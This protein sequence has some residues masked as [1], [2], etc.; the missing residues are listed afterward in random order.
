MLLVSRLSSEIVYPQT[1]RLS[2]TALEAII[3]LAVSEA[4]RFLLALPLIIYSYNGSNVHR[5]VYNKNK[6]LGWLGAVFAAL[7]LFNFISVSITN[8]KKEIGI[9]R[10]VGARG[11]DVFKIFFSESGIIVGICL[12]LSVIGTII[13]TAVLNSLLYYELG[14]FVSL[15]VFGPL[16]VLMMVGIAFVVAVLATFLPVYFAAKK[17]PVESIRAL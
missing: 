17:K 1:V 2:G 12:V 14:L 9:L 5:S 10:A 8:K 7:L 4:I 16:S 11:A 3:A 15:F 13:V 6:T